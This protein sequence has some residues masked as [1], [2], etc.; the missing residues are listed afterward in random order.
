ME[1]VETC[2]VDARQ[3]LQQFIASN[4]DSRE[5]K[6]AL[7]VQMLLQGFR[8]AKIQ[9]VLGVSAAFVSRCK[10]R[11]VLEGVEGLK[12]KH[13]GSKGY[14]KPRERTS[15]IEWLKN[16]HRIILKEL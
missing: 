14:L 10:G 13:Q 5:L 16:K 12:L 1:A 9:E 3:E 7:A 2:K 11:Y 8:P 4:R 15:I 6:R